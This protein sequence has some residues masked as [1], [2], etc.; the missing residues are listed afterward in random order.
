MP[1]ILQIHP[2]DNLVVAIRAVNEAVHGSGLALLNAPG[3]DGVSS[4]AQVVER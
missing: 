4:T 2:S 1:D 3:N